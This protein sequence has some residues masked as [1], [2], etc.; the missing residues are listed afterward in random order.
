MASIDKD[1]KITLSDL[2]QIGEKDGIAIMGYIARLNF[3]EV[4]IS[5]TGKT[6]RD[7]YAHVMIEVIKKLQEN[8]W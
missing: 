2:V 6:P 5:N 8:T 7:A 1:F 4:N 3:H